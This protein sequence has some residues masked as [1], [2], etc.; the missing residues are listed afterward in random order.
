M[1][2]WKSVQHKGNAASP[3]YMRRFPIDTQKVE[4]SFVQNITT[5]ADDASVVSAIINMGKS[6]HM[7]VVAE[8][9]ET[10]EQLLFLREHDCTEAQGYYFSRPVTGEKIPELL[11]QSIKERAPEPLV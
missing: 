3:S 6:L 7:R 9:V 8:G 1:S 11:R 10:R 2:M 5:D 4:R